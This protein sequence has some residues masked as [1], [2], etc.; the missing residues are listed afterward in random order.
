MYLNYATFPYK[1][2]D[3]S[4]GRGVRS[5][6]GMVGRFRSDD[7]RVCDCQ[8]NL[9]PIVWCNRLTH[10]FCKKNQFVSIPFSSRDTWT[11]SW[12]TL[13]KFYGFCIIFSI[14]YQFSSQFSIQ[15]APFFIS[16]RSYWPSFYKTLDLIGSIF[17]YR[18]PNLPTEN[19]V[20]YPHPRPF[21][22]SLMHA[23]LPDNRKSLTT[24]CKHLVE[25][26]WVDILV[27]I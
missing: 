16:F 22:H 4:C 2:K 26:V 27:C 17:F 1:Y 25:C 15:L 12:S 6:L 24:Y 9:V 19:L 3:L 20:K 23:H 10:S 7:P 11:W 13:N 5:Y 21:T 8:S 18:M 14:L